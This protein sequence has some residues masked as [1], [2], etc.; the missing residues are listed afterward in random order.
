MSLCVLALRLYI[1][2]LRQ[3]QQGLL[4]KAL[5]SSQNP[6]VPSIPPSPASFV[7]AVAEDMAVE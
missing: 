3:L 1:Q 4:F 6:T 7:G 5:Q 2:L